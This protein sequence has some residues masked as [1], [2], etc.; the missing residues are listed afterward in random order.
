MLFRE[1]YLEKI[2]RP[3]FMDAATHKPKTVY[4]LCALLELP[5]NSMHTVA[6][7]L[8]ELKIP[9]GD[10]CE[11]SLR[12][13]KM[14]ESRGFTQPRND[15]STDPSVAPV[16]PLLAATET[17]DLPKKKRKKLLSKSKTK[18]KKVKKSSGKPGTKSK[19]HKHI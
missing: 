7:W 15:S 4:D 14:M 8:R 1:E 12:A 18:G 5:P 10:I 3:K 13:R 6:A 2:I 16:V 11:L 17:L 9:L 19:S